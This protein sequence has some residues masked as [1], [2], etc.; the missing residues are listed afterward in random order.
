MTERF[1]KQALQKQILEQQMAEKRA[2][3]A[4]QKQKELEME[5][6]D[7]MRLRNDL[8]RA[9]QEQTNDRSQIDERQISPRLTGQQQQQPN[10]QDFSSVTDE[11]KPGRVLTQ[12][13]KNL[14][15][16]KSN[17]NQQASQQKTQLPASSYSRHASYDKIVGE[18]SISPQLVFKQNNFNDVFQEKR[19]TSSFLVRPRSGQQTSLQDQLVL[20]KLESQFKQELKRFKEEMAEQKQDFAQV[21]SQLR[22]DAKKTIELRKTAELHVALEQAKRH[23]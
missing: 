1:Q 7:E 18:R 3:K 22:D 14:R 5:Y 23:Q 10:N 8:D 15:H 2:E 12:K 21:L 9:Q 20:N 4:A 13:E 11:T 19:E 6:R 17:R 16:A